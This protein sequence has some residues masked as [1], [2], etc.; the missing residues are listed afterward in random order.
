MVK[1]EN[2][3]EI[4]KK[5]ILRVLFKAWKKYVFD[6]SRTANK[7]SRKKWA[8]DLKAF[9]DL[10]H[11]KEDYVEAVSNILLSDQDVENLFL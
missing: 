2:D 11:I 3:K 6:R 9:L 1:R 10:N 7:E 4:W 5:T 8:K